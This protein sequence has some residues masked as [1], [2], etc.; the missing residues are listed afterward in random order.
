MRRGG[1]RKSAANRKKRQVVVPQPPKE[2]RDIGPTFLSP[3]SSYRFVDLVD[4]SKPKHFNKCL[5][6]SLNIRIRFGH[7]FSPRRSRLP[8]RGFRCFFSVH[9][10]SPVGSAYFVLSRWS[11]V[12]GYRRRSLSLSLSVSRSGRSPQ[13]PAGCRFAGDNYIVF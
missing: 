3:S 6:S 10:A 4:R 12:D 13:S 11:A 8:C 9:V 5:C 1:R 7:E 2:V